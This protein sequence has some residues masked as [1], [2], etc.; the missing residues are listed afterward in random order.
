MFLSRTDKI[1]DIKQKTLLI[2]KNPFLKSLKNYCMGKNGTAVYWVEFLN[3]HDLLNCVVIRKTVVKSKD[4][5]YGNPNF[6]LCLL[7]T[8]HA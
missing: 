1:K 7:H 4:Y 3:S 5:F 2:V 6:S 8:L